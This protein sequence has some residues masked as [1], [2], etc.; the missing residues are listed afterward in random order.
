MK[1]DKED[2]RTPRYQP[3]APERLDG[4]G[5]SCSRMPRQPCMSVT[6]GRR[7]CFDPWRTDVLS[8]SL[9]GDP[10]RI[11]PLLFVRSGWAYQSYQSV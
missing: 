3:L 9:M 7:P 2:P 10:F 8:L 1:H 4:P 11:R 6:E 5:G